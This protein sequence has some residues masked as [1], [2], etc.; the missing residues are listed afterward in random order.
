MPDTQTIP[1]E[2]NPDLLSYWLNSEEVLTIVKKNHKITLVIFAIAIGYALLIFAST[3]LFFQFRPPETGRSSY[4]FY[5]Y[6]IFPLIELTMAYLY[7]WAYFTIN[8]A[9]KQFL[10]GF[11]NGN[12]SVLSFGFSLFYKTNLVSLGVFIVNTAHAMF[13]VWSMNRWV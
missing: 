6:R 3:Y 12:S 8:K 4:F 1:Q 5:F 11:S 2:N 9:Y 13:V 10:N 7:I